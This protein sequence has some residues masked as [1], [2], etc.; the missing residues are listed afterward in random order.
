MGSWKKFVALLGP[1]LLMAGAAI[2]VSHLVQSTRAGADYGLQLAFV[3]LL[4]NLFKYPFF[5]FGHRYAAATGQ[6]LLQGYALMGRRY[7]LIF[8]LL[9]LVSAIISLAGVTMVT[10]GLAEYLFGGVGGT[11][12]WSAFFFLISIALL[13]MGHYR[14]LDRSMKFLMVILLLSTV[15]ACLAAGWHGPVAPSD[16]SSPNPWSKVGLGFL[17]ALMGWMPA[18]VELSVWQSLWLQARERDKKERYTLA[19]ARLDFNVGYGLS[20]V[21]ALLFLFMG[22]WVM[23]GSG[24]VFSN[25]GSVFASQIVQLYQEV[26]GDWAGPVVALAALAAMFS[27][28]ITCVDAYPRSLAVATEL[29]FPRFQPDGRRHHLV[30]MLLCCGLG[31]VIILRYASEM[32]NLIDLATTLAFLAAP[33]FAFLNYRLINSAAVSQEM[34]PGPFLNAL[35]VLGMLF[36]SLFSL[37]FLWFRFIG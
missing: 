12:F 30:W 16:F 15:V 9:N 13:S 21:M 22:A 35:A 20:V 33:F 10:A 1:G 6:N 34:K 18:P 37:V 25:A 36:L 28:V 3:I 23:H 24:L 7:L 27:T 29:I 8:F 32:K 17:I 14:W 4:V 19:E 2:G 11:V 31:F 5:E 26:L